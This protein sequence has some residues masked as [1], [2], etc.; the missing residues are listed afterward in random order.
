VQLPSTLNRLWLSCGLGLW[1]ILIGCGFWTLAH[2]SF[3]PGSAGQPRSAWPAASHLAHNSG[4]YT[5]VV[6]LHPECPCSAATLTE[7]AS[8]LPESRGQ[9]RTQVVFAD[10]DEIPTRPEA[11]ALW[12]QASRLPGV[13]VSK[14]SDG[15]EIRNFAAL[16]SGET[17]LYGPNGELLFQ[18]GITAARGH[19]G[20]N[21]GQAAVADWVAGRHP[22][23]APKSLPAFGCAL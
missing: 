17:R 12:R 5:L 3:T 1:L 11:S 22:A 16:T 15:T 21:P 13:S 8:I 6:L 14:D 20:D 9:L 23:H 10:Y 7:L 2:Y 19:V 18:G 4:G